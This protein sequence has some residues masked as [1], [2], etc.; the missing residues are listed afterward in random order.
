MTLA[1]SSTRETF[2]MEKHLKC[3][4]CLDIFNDPVTTHCGHSF[5][6]KCLTFS[7]THTDMVCP[8][9]K[10]LQRKPPAVNIVLREIVEQEKLKNK[11]EENE[12]AYTGKDGEVA[13]DVCTQQKLKAKK[14]CL[15]CLAS[16]CSA[17][18]ENHSSTER[19]K[20]HKLVE[21]VKN[22]DDRAC[23]KHGRPLELYSRKQQRCICVRCMDD[24][25][26]EVV[27]TEDEWEKKKV[28]LENAKTELEEK[29]KKRE[30]Q[31]A[32]V[33]KSLQDCKD[34]LDNEWWDIDAVFE[35]IIAIV[36]QARAKV[37]Q[38]LIDRRQVL[39]KEAENLMKDLETEIRRF[40]TTISELEGISALEDHIQF[41]QSYP[42]LQDLEDIKDWA[43]I[44]L[45]TSV[46]F[47]TM[48]KSTA[49]MTERIQQ[50]LEK[51]TSTEL[52]RVP[53]FAVDIKLDPNTA[54]QRLNLSLDGKEVKDGEKQQEVD[55]APERFDMFGSV[56]GLN[57]L[58]SG[59]SY[60]EV[61]VSNKTGWDLGVA[62][63]DAN[64]KGKLSLSPDDGYWV[65]V[66]Y[67]DDKYAALVA[68]PLRLSL[69][70][71][72]QKVGLFVDYD[73]G[74]V[75]FYNVTDES[76]IYTF[77]GCSFGDELFPYFSPHVHQEGK[78]ADPLVISAVKQ[79]EQNMDES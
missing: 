61:E 78:N 43:E 54:H 45:D 48:R 22:L 33:R 28:K 70:D 76:H 24:S 74:L 79:S 57:N 18:L 2:S 3:S 47:G 44:E 52:K 34:Q 7:F 50:E 59:K 63:G 21:P 46:S 68:P 53:K 37:H 64:R 69:K 38:P 17:H 55:E 23:L 29:I 5:C 35:A 72:P 31:L 71:K 19:L 9:C 14:S 66:H 36:E 67:E 26:E 30:T 56:L 6:K 25:P 32:E 62:R 15:V 41:L 12:D 40:K 42:P 1:A 73:E 49:I 75:S 11:E 20:G 4:I 27:S 58:N 60:W 51:L 16:Y 65:T 39:E 8:L 13:C 10:E 77:T